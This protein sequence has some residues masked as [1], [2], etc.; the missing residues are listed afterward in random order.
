MRAEDPNG[1]FAGLLLDERIE[2]ILEWFR[3][4]YL[5][6]DG[7]PHYDVDGETGKPL[8]PRSLLSELGDY[9]PFIAASGD[10]AYVRN[11]VQL[12]QKQLESRP[13]LF[14]AP[15][16]RVH[17]GVRLSL[18]FNIRPA[19]TDS[20]DYTE[21]LYGLLELHQLWQ[22]YSLIE[23]ADRV[24]QQVSALFARNGFI[25]TWCLL[26]PR[27]ALPVCE[28]MNGMY[29]EIFADFFRATRDRQYL[30]SARE[31][32]DHWVSLPNFREKGFF[33]SVHLLSKSMTWIPRFRRIA[34]RAELV[35]Y[36][37]CMASG[38]M[39]L[40]RE[41][42]GGPWADHLRH[43]ASG[44]VQHFQFQ[45]GV[46]YHLSD[47]TPLLPQFPERPVLSTNFAIIEI[48]ADLFHA[49]GDQQYFE[50]A[51]AG[52]DFWLEQQ[53][54]R[55]GLFPDA[56]GGDTSYLDGNT[57]LI[58]AL[59]RMFELTGEDKYMHSS[60]RALKGILKYHRAPCGYMRDVGLE[61]GKP[62]CPNVETRFVSLLL[63][64]LLLFQRGWRIY[65]QENMSDILRDR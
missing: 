35:K 45:P 34:A 14:D 59:M 19:H 5:R 58:M 15:Q 23:L 21:I 24:L 27:W 50:L 36:N 22:D 18:P 11:Q 16:A 8:S 51:L 43:W 26:R 54:A 52:A 17:A 12:L 9:V 7:F 2:E 13:S 42:P 41:D 28:S 61:T 25:A 62:L 32:A 33:P 55:T 40:F 4:T 57:D 1:E 30:E 38:L 47:D 48:F 63:K 3:S 53:S 20:L 46:F 56:V 65:G 64:P 49:L 39:A 10:A 37:S 29:I 6:E 60:L 44:I 31:L